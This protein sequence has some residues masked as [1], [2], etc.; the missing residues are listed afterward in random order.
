[1]F[2]YG[3][4]VIMPGGERHPGLISVPFF[5][6]PRPRP[7]A[8]LPSWDLCNSV[9]CTPLGGGPMT[10][11]KV[12]RACLSHFPNSIS[13]FRWSHIFLGTTQAEPPGIR[14][15]VLCQGFNL[16]PFG[17]TLHVFLVFVLL[18]ILRSRKND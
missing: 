6:L 12:R 14:G 9:L 17:F 3:F 13:L 2:I 5:C 11:F 8:A 10:M 1:M 18:F 7:G 15:P 4:T 16:V